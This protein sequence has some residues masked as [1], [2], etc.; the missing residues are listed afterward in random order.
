MVNVPSMCQM[1]PAVFPSFNMMPTV[2]D[3]WRVVMF[4]WLSSVL[5]SFNGLELD[6]G[7]HCLEL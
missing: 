4:L 2:K 1:R 5:L 7:Q 6:S 3:N